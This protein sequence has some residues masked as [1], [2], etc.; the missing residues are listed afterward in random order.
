[1]DTG[2]VTS[3]RNKK[4]LHAQTSEIRG[5]EECMKFRDPG[6]QIGAMAVKDLDQ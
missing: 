5:D 1:M 3:Y 2:A 4:M 6:A